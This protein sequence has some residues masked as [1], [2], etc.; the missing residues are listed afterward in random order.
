MCVILSATVTLCCLF[1]PKM[2]IVLLHPEKYARDMGG[3]K[4]GGAGGQRSNSGATGGGP[5][6]VRIRPR[7]HAWI[8]LTDIVMSD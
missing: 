5:G 4:G 7:T 6:A 8:Y 2:Y 1:M 3:N